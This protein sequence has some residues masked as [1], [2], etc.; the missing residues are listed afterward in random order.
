MLNKS[1]PLSF[2]S[3]PNHSF[4]HVKSVVL[5]KAISTPVLF[6]LSK[7]G[8]NFLVIIYKEFKRTVHTCEVGVCVCSAGCEGEA[9]TCTWACFMV[10]L[11]DIPLAPYRR[12]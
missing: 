9:N 5:Y 11:I 1:I 7:E 8:Q 6:D 10:R 4:E 2:F 12:R 3:L